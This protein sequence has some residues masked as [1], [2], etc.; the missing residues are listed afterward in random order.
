MPRTTTAGRLCV[1]APSDTGSA[2]SDS[3]RRAERFRVSGLSARRIASMFAAG[4]HGDART[5]SIS[6][7][8]AHRRFNRPLVF[9]IPSR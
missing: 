9:P 6:H 5:G 1:D 7:L 8:R 2:L 4:L 3:K